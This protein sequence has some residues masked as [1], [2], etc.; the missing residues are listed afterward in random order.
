MDKVCNLYYGSF[1]IL[2]L[3]DRTKDKYKQVNKVYD[4]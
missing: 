1:S 2:N 3:N 4:L